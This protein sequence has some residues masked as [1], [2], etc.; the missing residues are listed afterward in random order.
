MW[1]GTVVESLRILVCL[2]SMTSR[3]SSDEMETVCLLYLLMLFSVLVYGTDK[4]NFLS[5]FTD[6][7]E[8]KKH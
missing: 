2:I 6:D 1:L 3:L 8:D 5:Q 7:Q 4:G